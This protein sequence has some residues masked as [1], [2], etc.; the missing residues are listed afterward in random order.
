MTFQFITT[1]YNY[2]VHIYGFTNEVLRAA[3]VFPYPDPADEADRRAPRAS[4][5][6]DSQA[7]SPPRTTCTSGP[8]LADVTAAGRAEPAEACWSAKPRTPTRSIRAGWSSDR[9]TTGA[10]MRSMR[11]RTTRVYRRQGLELHGRASV[12]YRH[13]ISRSPLRV[14][15]R[16][17]SGPEKTIDGSGLNAASGQHSTEPKDMWLSSDSRPAALDP[18]RVRP[19]PQAGPDARLELQPGAR[20]SSSASGQETSHRVLRRT[21]TTWNA[22]G[23][24]EL[25]RASGH[26]RLTRPT[27]P[28][29]SAARSPSTSS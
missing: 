26:S 10:S 6:L 1:V 28:S 3:G 27:P 21:P 23:D 9:P 8:S 15:H 5:F 29:T 16:R 13:E 25:A 19:S 17:D 24:F 2:G 7:S 11:R 20:E 14:L 4:F 12:L 22:L 18:V